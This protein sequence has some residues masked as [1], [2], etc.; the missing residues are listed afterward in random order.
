M[1]V[2]VAQRWEECLRAVEQRVTIG[3]PMRGYVRLIGK[4]NVEIMILAIP[5]ITMFTHDK[6]LAVTLASVD[7]TTY[8]FSTLLICGCKMCGSRNTI[9]HQCL[10]CLNK[11]YLGYPISFTWEHGFCGRLWDSVNI[12]YLTHCTFC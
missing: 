8:R 9:L 7:D 1:T 4:S 2:F 10:L 12:Y 5:N 11:K 6:G 3:Q